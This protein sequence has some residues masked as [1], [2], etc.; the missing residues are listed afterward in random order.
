ME[1]TGLRFSHDKSRRH[2]SRSDFIS[3]ME[4]LL[5]AANYIRS[6]PAMRF[7][8]AQT[9][10]IS[11]TNP[12]VYDAIRDDSQPETW[13]WHHQNFGTGL[14]IFTMSDL[15]G[16]TGKADDIW[17]KSNRLKFAVTNKTDPVIDQD[18]FLL[19]LTYD[20]GE[21]T[22]LFIYGQNLDFHT[23]KKVI[24]GLYKPKLGSY[25]L[26]NGKYTPRSQ[27]KNEFRSQS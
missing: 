18:E 27:L 14:E 22:R 2:F 25:K 5:G 9:I 7:P 12:I 13:Y 4:S 24:E 23:R 8:P 17:K 3:R 21:P 15:H 11:S 26:G 20:R 16:H 19:S 6:I 10:V 1:E